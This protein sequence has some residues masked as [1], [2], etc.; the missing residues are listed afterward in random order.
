VQKCRR[1]FNDILLRS[2]TPCLL[3]FIVMEL[4]ASAI[5]PAYNE[6]KTVGK[7]T[8]TLVQSGVFQDV[9]VV[10]DGSSDQTAEAAEQAGATVI[11]SANNQGKGRAMALG[12]RST[13]S[14]VVCFFDAD[15]IGLQVEHIKQLVAPVAA[16]ELDMHVGTVDRGSFINTLSSK[17]PAVSG[18]RALRREVFEGVPPRHVAGF[19]IETALNYSCRTSGRSM[20]RFYLR[21]VTIIRKIQKVGL[22][23]GLRGYLRMWYRVLERMILVR[24]DRKS[25]QSRS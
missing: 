14:P 25:F 15:L 20:R 19:G 24:L 2:F 22:L 18:Q 16:G 11:R 7:V 23:R 12:V 1:N 3:Y 4:K 13:D 10:D 9:I 5:I 6:E 21:N 17:L 8:K